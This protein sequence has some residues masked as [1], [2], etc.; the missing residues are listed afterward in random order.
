MFE[1]KIYIFVRKNY[2]IIRK[3]KISFH[4]D[5]SCKINIIV[6]HYFFQG[7]LAEN[8]DNRGISK[9]GPAAPR[10]SRLDIIESIADNY[11]AH[12]IDEDQVKNCYYFCSSVLL[13]F[14][15]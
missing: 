11:D 12:E 9:E 6:L 4:T 1:N 14:T 3:C 13:L 5:H 8:D 7:E 10:K 15:M 2:K